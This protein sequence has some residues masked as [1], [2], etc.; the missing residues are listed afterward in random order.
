[1]N[2]ASLATTHARLWALVLVAAASRPAAG[3][4]F[5]VSP[6]VVELSASHRM[7][8]IT[9]HNQSD[10]PALIQVRATAWSQR[11]GADRYEETQELLATPPVFELPAASEQ[12][13]RVALRRD[14]DAARELTFRVFVQEVPTGLPIIANG[15]KVALRLG[16]PVFVLPAQPGARPSLQWLGHRQVDGNLE[17]EASNPGSV[18]VRIARFYL[19]LGGATPLQVADSRYVLTGSR[20]TWQVSMPPELNRQAALGIS[21]SSDF[22]DFAVRAAIVGP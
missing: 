20:V 21:G 16:I 9:V 7:D 11:D 6:T 10:T 12:I 1:M 22:G 15:L 17:I 3:G 2:K 19:D 13:I 5:G 8:V 14:P 4:S 18:H